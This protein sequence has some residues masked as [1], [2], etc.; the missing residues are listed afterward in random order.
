VLFVTA[1]PLCL[2]FF[3]LGEPSIW[4]DESATWLNASDG[5]RWMW[6]AAVSGEDCG[7]FVYGLVM[8]LWTSVFGYGETALRTPSVL[9]AAATSLVLLQ[10]GRGLGNLRAG[11]CMAAC[12]MLHP[13]VICWSRQARAYS[14]EVLLT[15]AYLA[16]ILAYARTGGRMRAVALTIVGA[17]LALTHV[18]GVFVVIG[19]TLF[20]LALRFERSAAESGLPARRSLAPSIIAGLLLG[21]W[22]FAMQSRVKQNLDSFWI[23]GSPAEKYLDVLRQL[24][25]FYG[26]VA[27][28]VAAGAGLLLM[29]RRLP[30]ERR[31]LMAAGLILLTVAAGPAAASALSRGDHH[32]I[33]PRYFLPGVVPVVVFAGYFLASLPRRFAVLGVLVLGA[34]GISTATA[35]GVFSDSGKDGGRTRAA[36]QFF[37]A[38]FR[39]GDRLFITPRYEESTLR[40][41]GVPSRIVLGVG[42]LGE[43]DQLQDL[44]RSEPPQADAR[45]WVMVYHC[46]DADDLGGLVPADCPQ[47]RFGMIRLVRV[48]AKSAAPAAS[49]AE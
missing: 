43:R 19:G 20:L 25:P 34:A 1:V 28:L 14:L 21:C 18:F 8:K 3:R 42:Q 26:A 17:L 40:Y 37:A 22:M 49:A 41:Y 30:A 5:W 45:N 31:L 48:D 38:N 11:V 35:D 46:D 24:M 12:G 44:L 36:L 32:F 29:R 9:F 23:D 2:G 39:K 15:A 7:G 13:V 4:F 27:L 47:E 6:V 33:F 16:I 10:I